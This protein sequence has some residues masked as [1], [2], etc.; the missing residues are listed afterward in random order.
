MP[1]NYIV[2]YPD[3]PQESDGIT[4]ETNEARLIVPYT[5]AM[6][7]QIAQVR[8]DRSLLTHELSQLL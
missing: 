1:G 2:S 7:M 8:R 6:T 5:A 3:R 4:R